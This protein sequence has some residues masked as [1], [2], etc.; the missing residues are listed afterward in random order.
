MIEY[1]LFSFFVFIFFFVIEFNSK[2]SFFLFLINKEVNLQILFLSSLTNDIF[3][4]IS[5]N[6]SEFFIFFLKNYCFLLILFVSTVFSESLKK[7][8][9]FFSIEKYLLFEKVSF[10]LKICVFFFVN[11]LFFFDNFFW[12]I[13]L[14]N[15]FFNVFFKFSSKLLFL[16]KKLLF[17][18]FSSE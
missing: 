14:K 9:Q 11:K 1:K 17:T 18:F 4:L 6:F 15:F 3:F 2:K 5:F 16:I 10:L 7:Q 13:F 12:L 8:S